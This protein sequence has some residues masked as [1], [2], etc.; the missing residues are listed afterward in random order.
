MKDYNFKSRIF[1][2]YEHEKSMLWWN[3]IDN[4]EFLPIRK[5]IDKKYNVFFKKL[6]SL[7]PNKKKL[8]SNKEKLKEIFYLIVYQRINSIFLL[9][10]SFLADYLDEMKILNNKKIA[11]IR[12]TIITRSIER[13]KPF[14]DDVFGIPHL[15]LF[16]FE[17]TA[18]NYEETI[19]DLIDK[20]R[21]YSIKL[22]KKAKAIYK[23]KKGKKPRITHAEALILANDKLQTYEPEYLRDSNGFDTDFFSNMQDAFRKQIKQL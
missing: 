11:L 8:E 13:A 23:E 6:H 5:I 22:F 12:E 4:E 14:V 18:N 20:N 10:E 3:F 7:S 15:I 17:K 21:T 19:I 9:E 2:E 16:A 1:K